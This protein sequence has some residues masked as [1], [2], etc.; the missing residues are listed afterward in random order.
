MYDTQSDITIE[1]ALRLA[2]SGY[3][4][5]HIFRKDATLYFG[6]LIFITTSLLPYIYYHI[7]RKDAT[8][9]CNKC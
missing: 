7:F 9:N 5:Y 3:I 8:L 1:D 2:M 6:R 4:S